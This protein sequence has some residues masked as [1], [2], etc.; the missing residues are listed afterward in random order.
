MISR[1]RRPKVVGVPEIG[2]RAHLVSAFDKISILCELAAKKVEMGYTHLLAL[3]T[4][5]PLVE[6][7]FR[8]LIFQP[9]FI[10]LDLFFFDAANSS[11]C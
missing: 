10:F 4:L 7:A 11:Y 9:A 5:T 3:A 8:A 2:R 6:P 1:A